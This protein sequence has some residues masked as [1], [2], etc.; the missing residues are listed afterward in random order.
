MDKQWSE[1]NKKMQTLI[2][3]EATFSEGI[4]VLLE[5]R[6]SHGRS[7]MFFVLKTLFVTL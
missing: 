7:D 4:K 3:K 5:L 2:A 1:N 6:N